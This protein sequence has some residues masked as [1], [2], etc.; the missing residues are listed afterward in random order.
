MQS[1]NNEQLN[2]TILKFN[3]DFN[4]IFGKP[5]TVPRREQEGS[6]YFQSMLDL[7]H[8]ETDRRRRG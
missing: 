2:G 8:L 1:V 7:A 6:Q 3:Q 4:E 5:C